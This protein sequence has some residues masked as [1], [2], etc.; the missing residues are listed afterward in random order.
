V[1]SEIRDRPGPTHTLFDVLAAGIASLSPGR[2]VA[3]LGFAGGG[4]V[5]PLRAM[6]CDAPLRC[7]DLSLR[8][9]RLFRRLAGSWGGEV[10]VDQD[11]A[12]RWL[13]RQR[14]RFDCI[15][16]DISLPSTPESLGTKPSSSLKE[17][18]PLL[19]RRLA[20]NGVAIVNLLPQPGVP[21]GQLVRPYQ[22]H[23]D[24]VQVVLFDG[25]VNRVVVA[26]HRLGAARDTSRRLRSALHD[27]ESAMAYEVHVRTLARSRAPR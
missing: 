26:G 1:I 10:R 22:R 8:G 6:R 16:E 20:A 11:D 23:F 18:P 5:A 13:Q 24:H 14:R 12:V 19:S 17:L 21:W 4:V 7:V 27:I 2:R 9:E 3:V 25:Y 15:L